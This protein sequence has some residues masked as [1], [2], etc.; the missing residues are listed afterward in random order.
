M[1]ET[2]ATTWEVGQP[3]ARYSDEKTMG[4]EHWKIEITL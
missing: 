2:L 3:N 4:D 1:T